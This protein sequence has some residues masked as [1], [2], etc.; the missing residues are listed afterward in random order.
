MGKLDDVKAAI[1]SGI[2][3]IDVR[4]PGE[5]AEGH[6]PGAVNIPLRTVAQSLDMI[7]S[8]QPVLVYCASGLRAGTGHGCA[9]PA[10]LRQRESVPRR[11]EGLE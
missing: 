5:Y 1:D 6:I 9:A 8:D 7:P 4:E 11:L 10:R 2:Y 3:L